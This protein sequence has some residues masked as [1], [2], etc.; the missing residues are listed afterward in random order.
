MLGSRACNGRT[1]VLNAF[2]LSLAVRKFM[3]AKPQ[4]MFSRAL[5]FNTRNGIPHLQ[6]RVVGVIQAAQPLPSLPVWPRAFLPFL[7]YFCL[8]GGSPLA[9]CSSDSP[10]F[11]DPIPFPPP[12][13]HTHLAW[14]H[15]LSTS[16]RDRHLDEPQRQFCRR[17][18]SI[19]LLGAVRNNGRGR[20]PWQDNFAGFYR[21]EDNEGGRE[22]PHNIVGALACYA[23]CC[24]QRRS[25]RRM[26]LHPC[27][28]PRPNRPLTRLCF[29]CPHH[30]TA[31]P[32]DI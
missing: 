27:T 31:G 19:G 7:H 5:V 20:A 30:C 11:S 2:V 16:L 8:P 24:G 25:M 29:H 28:P 3:R 18:P 32:R 9:C 4:M 10:G 22:C 15:P 26:E 14:A 21:P 13:I 23:V 6:F 17:Y 1:L 12:H